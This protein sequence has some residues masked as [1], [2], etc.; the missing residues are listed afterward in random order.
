MKKLFIKA[1][2]EYCDLDRHVAAPLIRKTFELDAVPESALVSICGLGFYRFFVNGREITKGHIAPYISNPDH[3]CYYDNYDVKDLLVKGKNV[4]GIILG[5]GFM[6]CFGGAVWDFEKPDFRGAPRLALEFTA[7]LG[8]AEISFHA[9]DSFKTCHSALL[10]DDIRLGEIYDAREEKDGWALPDYDD[11]DWSAALYA[12]TPR[13]DMRLCEA[14]PIAVTDVIHPVSITKEGDA[15]LYDFGVNAAGVCRLTVNA[16]EGQRI[17]MWH[18]E[19]LNEGKFYNENIRFKLDKH[20]FYE[21]YNQTI[22]YIASGKGTEIYMP[23]FFY[24]GFRYVLVEGITEEQATADLLTYYVMSSDL[25]TVGGF[26]CSNDDLNRLYEMAVNSDRS[27]FFYF[28]TDCPHREKNGWTG[29]AS[30]SADHMALMYDVSASWRTWLDNIRKAQND[31]G[32]LPGIV[33]TGGWGFAWGNGPTWDSVLFNLPYMLFKFRGETEVIKENAH[34]MM[35]Y[36]NYVLTR[37]NE[38]GTIAI[39]LGDWVPVGKVKASAYD[40]PLKLTDT[41]MVMDM[42]HKAYEML[43]AIGYTH[44]ASYALGIYEDMRETIRRELIDLNTMTVAGNC[45]SSQCISL[46]YGVFNAD[47]EQ[48]AFDRLV[49]FIEAKGGAFDCGFIG[50][51]TILHVLTKFGR[52]DIAMKMVAGREFPAYGY[53]LEMGETSIPEKIMSDPMTAGS[54]NHHFLGDY[55]RWLTFNVAGLCVLDS[56]TVKITV[57]DFDNVDSAS[58][59]YDLPAGR[60]G[61]EWTKTDNGEKKIEVIAPEGV[62]VIR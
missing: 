54:H 55:A 59:W 5:N 33:P 30:M 2:E 28:P 50:L 24:G 43:S 8:E 20:P 25:K 45:Q 13:G 53:M 15:Y 58:A 34:A 32:E 36:L 48:M 62:T 60:V 11:S 23:S 19:I 46:Y 35:R 39:G 10:M 49:E 44:D 6:N 40:A 4:F 27:N 38:D 1:T 42:A 3:I 14:D 12:E 7:L 41:V 17:T 16:T 18:G 21:K 37:R 56:K 31:R 9:D 29:D 57:G 22:R 52:N 51:H 61:I 47:E 26:T